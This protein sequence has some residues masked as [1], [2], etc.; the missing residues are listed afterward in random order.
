M[1][2][3]LSVFSSHGSSQPVLQNAPVFQ[4]FDVASTLSP[5]HINITTDGFL[6]YLIWAA[7]SIEG[8][9][10]SVFRP[11]NTLARA[12]LCMVRWQAAF[13]ALAHQMP[14]VTSWVVTTQAISWQRRTVTQ[15]SNTKFLNLQ[16]SLGSLDSE[17]LWKPV[18]QQLQCSK[19]DYGMQLPLLNVD[20]MAIFSCQVDYTWN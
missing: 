17:M 15:L 20:V 19:W 10:N 16:L 1:L 3:R 9:L 7:F 18:S 13:R 2:W 4:H 8:Y 11:E 12:V 6:V 5:I 14:E